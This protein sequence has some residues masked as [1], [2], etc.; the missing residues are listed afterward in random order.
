MIDLEY[1]YNRPQDDVCE[2]GDPECLGA[3]DVVNQVVADLAAAL[4]TLQSPLLRL[5]KERDEARELVKRM[6]MATEGMT[7]SEEYYATMLAAHR[8]AMTWKG[9]AK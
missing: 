3:A 1:N 2:C 6:L 4:P 7:D 5:K 9:G 8:A